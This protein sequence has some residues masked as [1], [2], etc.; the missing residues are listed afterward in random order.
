MS[1]QHPEV[2]LTATNAPRPTERGWHPDPSAPG[3]ER[4]YDGTRWT[5]ETRDASPRPL[6]G[7]GV[8]VGVGIA[9]AFTACICA[10]I[11]AITSA[12]GYDGARDAAGWFVFAGIAGTVAT[13]NV[14][15]GVYRIAEQVNATYLRGQ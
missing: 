6:R 5:G 15:F 13:I 14:L 11:G 1:A 9:F 8:P 12:Q 4:F 10:V 2:D 3:T 7:G